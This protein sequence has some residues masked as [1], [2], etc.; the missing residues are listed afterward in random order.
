MS[1]VLEVSQE[2]VVLDDASL[3]KL[4]NNLKYLFNI[5][6]GNHLTFILGYGSCR[7]NDEALAL[8]VTDQLKQ[9]HFEYEG[10]FNILVDDLKELLTIEVYA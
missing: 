6:S 7:T 8:W 2:K 9:Y 1:A 5:E 4:T 3:N 10:V